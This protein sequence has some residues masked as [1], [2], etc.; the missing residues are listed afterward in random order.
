MF[1]RMNLQKRTYWSENFYFS[2][3]SG[4]SWHV[5]KL[6]I[7]QGLVRLDDVLVG[8]DVDG[9]LPG[10]GQGDGEHPVINHV[11]AAWAWGSYFFYS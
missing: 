5:F 3:L 4:V 2:N 1:S 9:R 6:E 8:L 10:A 11:P 7:I